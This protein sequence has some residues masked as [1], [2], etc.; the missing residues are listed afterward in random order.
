M[1]RTRPPVWT[2]RPSRFAG[3]ARPRAWAALGIVALLMLGGLVALWRSVPVAP[4]AAFGEA[5]LRE[6]LVAGIRA[7]GDYY[8]VAESV[9]LVGRI[10]AAHWTDVPLPIP[11][12][13]IGQLSPLKALIVQWL[14]LLTVF[15]AWFVRL[16]HEFARIAPLA[17]VGVLLAGGLIAAA[18]PLLGPLN[19]VWAGLLIALSL[20]LRRPGRWIEA[21]AIGLAAMAVDEGAAL[22]ALLMAVLAYAEGAR[23]EAIGWA[24]ALLL[25]VLLFVTHGVAVSGLSAQGSVTSLIPGFGGYGL[26]LQAI[27]YTT[28]FA[29]LP[30]PLGAVL[31]ALALFGWASWR[32]ATGLRV[33]ATLAGYALL[34]ALFAPR[35]A[36]HWGYLAAPLVPLGLAFAP[37]GLRDMAAALLD[38]RRV[39]VQRISR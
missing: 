27:T 1:A 23:R 4:D 10:A 19:S 26:F 18:D 15:V 11:A 21:A 20:A 29:L 17:M 9:L 31:I 3:A 22:Y 2:S 5:M 36:I 16:R 14:L 25:F 32:D 35:G 30:L 34:I 37:D 39:R 24:A 12:V 7:G 28:A 33:L 38:R 6:G 8:S 13:L